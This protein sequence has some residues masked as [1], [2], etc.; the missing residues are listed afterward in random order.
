MPKGHNDPRTEARETWEKIH[1]KY[2]HL[3]DTKFTV[4]LQTYRRPKELNKT[5]HA[6]LDEKIPSLL[7]IVIIWNDLEANPP[8][9]FT[10]PLGTPVR[11]R[12]STR[13]SLNEK[14][15][16]DSTFR[17]QAIMLSDD[18]VYY[19]PRDLEFVF[20]SWRKF[21]RNK[22]TGA[23]ARCPKLDANGNWK[24]TLCSSR[25]ESSS[26]SMILT[27]LAMS[28]ISFLDYYSSDEPMMKKIRDY[29]DEK[30]NC[31]DIAMNFVHSYLTGEGPLLIQGWKRYVNFT[32]AKGI[33][34]KKGHLQA[35]SKCLNDFVDTFNS[36]PLVDE[37]GYLQRGV[38]A[39]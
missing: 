27:N 21:G 26:Y 37:I 2:E 8:A 20:Q 30:F 16:P 35:R 14:L 36:M 38:L 32:P 15:L 31:E 5:L 24:Y 7:E 3:D 19:H 23:L 34:M 28:H 10:S 13:N 33:S 9:N 6:L 4:A 17:T 1:A 39:L 11:Y 25:D 18:D 22:L 12:A 29:V